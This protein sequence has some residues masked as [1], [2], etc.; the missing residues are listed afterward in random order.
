MFLRSSL[1]LS[2][3]AILGFA[4]APAAAQSAAPSAGDCAVFGEIA[5][6]AAQERLA[7]TEMMQ[8]MV[9]IAEGYTGAQ[10]RFAGAVP[11]LVDWVWQL[12]EAQ[13]DDGVGAAYAEACRSQ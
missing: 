13:L 9:T 12:P 2:F 7:E 8:A 10:E 1:A 6:Q 11:L 3:T 5:E 4:A